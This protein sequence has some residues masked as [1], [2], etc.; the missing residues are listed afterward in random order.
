MRNLRDHLLVCL[1]VLVFAVL[2][3]CGSTNPASST[4]DSRS[5]QT[6]EASGDN[7]AS[8]T[9]AQ[10]DGAQVNTFKHDFGSIEV[11][12]HPQRIAGLYL[13][14]YLV[15]LGIKPVTQT[16]IGSFSLK[17]LQSSI[18]DL[19]KVDTSAIDYEAMLAARP[20]LILLAFPSYANDGNY[21]KFSSIAPTYVFGADAPDQWRE[22]LR[23][24]GELTGKQAEA[25]K[26]LQSYDSKVKDA[27][28]K[29]KAAIGDETVGFVRIRSNK[30][31]RLY[32]GPGGYVGNVLY[33]DLGLNPP[34]I[35]KD[36]AWGEDS[37]MAVISKEIIPEITADHLF[38]TYDEGG[39]DLA[40]ELINSNIWK[41]LPAVKNNQTYEVS[42]DHWMTF[43]PLAYNKKVD[44]VLQA[45][46]K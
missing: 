24:I 41:S 14:D 15:A 12:A 32:G 18:G 5:D 45:L 6:A 7:Q 44:D 28:A 2:T 8:T 16:V 29:L 35:A 13:E 25:E 42:M 3:A 23:T 22:A 37:G 38:I 17:Y 43:G 20:D 21:D 11:P 10:Q 27:K 1:I 39:K 46:V 33:T 19:P 34:Q 4:Q 31:I 26:V 40:Q 36:L 30:E 9:T